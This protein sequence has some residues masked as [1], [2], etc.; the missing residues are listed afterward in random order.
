MEMASW[1]GNSSEK[2]HFFIVPDFNKLNI[3]FFLHSFIEL[4][5]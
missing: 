4:V 1:F 5:I 2:Q 3:F